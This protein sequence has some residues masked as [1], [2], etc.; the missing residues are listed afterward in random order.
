[1]RIYDQGSGPPLIVVPGVQG[2][3][4]WFTPALAALNGRCRTISY[5]LAGDLGSGRK[6]DPA[7]GFEN[8]MRQLDELFASTGL[9]RA[10]LCGISYGA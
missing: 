2:R 6:L 3:W 10:A 9:T 4:E 5:T 1:M 8:Y 7:L